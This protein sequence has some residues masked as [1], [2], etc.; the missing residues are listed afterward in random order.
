MWR[1]TA[2]AYR[3]TEWTLLKRVRAGKGI[4]AQLRH[5]RHG[6]KLWVGTAHFTPGCTFAQYETEVENVMTS[7]PA[8]G[9]PA[10]FQCDANAPFMWRASEGVEQAVGR[11]VK[12]NELQ[13][14][15][16]ERGFQLTPPKPE[17]F[18]TPTSR[19]RQ[20]GRGGNIIDVIACRGMV[21]G[22]IAVHVDSCYVAG[23]DHEILE[24]T[25]YLRPRQKHVRHP[26]K[27]RVWTGGIDKVTYVDQ[28]TLEDLARQCTKPKPGNAYRDPPEVKNAVR[29]ARLHKTQAA[30]SEVR[31]LRKVARR[32]WE[33]DRVLRATQGDWAAFRGCKVLAGTGWIEGFAEAQTDDPHDI[34]HAHLAQ[35]YKGEPPEPNPSPYQGQVLAFTEAELDTALGQMQS[36]KSVGF[37]GTSKEL[38]VGLVEVEGG[39]QHLLEFLSRVL[40]TQEIPSQWNTPLMVLLP[41]LSQPLCPRDLRPISMGSGVCKLF[42]RLLLNRCSRALS[43]STH[44]QCAGPGRQTSDYL[45]A[46][47]RLVELER[48]W[49]RGL[50]AAK[51]DITKAFDMVSRERVLDKLQERLGDTAE[52]RCWRGLLQQNQGVL[53]T[54]W[55]TSRV[56]M[57]RGIKQGAVESPI[58][59]ALVAEMC[60]AEASSRYQWSKEE[61]VFQGLEFRD[62]LYMDDCLFW[63]RGVEGLERRI[64]QFA[65]VLSEYGLALNGKKCQ[66]YTS[67][68]WHGPTHIRICGVHV[69][70]SDSL[71]IMG[72]GMR[73]G[74]S[75]CELIGPLLARAKAKF[76][77]NKH[78]L[79]SH[80]PLKDRLKLLE[81]IAGGAVMWCLG[82]FPPDRSS[83]GLINACHFQ[84]VVWTLKLGKRSA[85]SWESFHKRSYRSARAVIHGVGLQRWGTTWIRRWWGFA[86]HRARGLLRDA[87]PI[88]THLDSFRSLVWWEAEQRKTDGCYTMADTT[89]GS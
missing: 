89:L 47:W 61:Q 32:Q 10:V 44:S 26:T 87:P 28:S 29:R 20:A 81:R 6:V 50:C 9:G 5:L 30:W 11:D 88:S 37:D 82:A 36:G 45:F 15:L 14:R 70:S 35:V 48:E 60:L 75:L 7:F 2:V 22:S 83:L 64:K 65:V 33:S 62:M 72:I 67:P 85:E 25:F 56:C 52:M 74:M 76:W 54:P 21:R 31:R 53:Q 39:K 27:P 3:E 59:F 18:S 84:L 1:G 73:V 68:Y 4:W 43:F 58:L 80:G 41:K 23:T 57:Q 51:L 38:L 46:S 63:G 13:G 24:G 12:A 42:S 69:Q 77:A 49:H 78:L 55:G 16:L 17:Q 86:G 71:E 40:T 34:V 19:P 8:V 79:R 66:L